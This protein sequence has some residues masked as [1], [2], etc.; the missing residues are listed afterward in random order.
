ML[1]TRWIIT[2]LTLQRLLNGFFPHLIITILMIW[3]KSQGQ[4]QELSNWLTISHLQKLIGWPTLPMKKTIN[5][6]TWISSLKVLKLSISGRRVPYGCGHL[7]ELFP[8]FSL[9]ANST[10]KGGQMRITIDIK[11]HHHSCTQMRTTLQTCKIS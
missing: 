8:C 6:K 3:P 5:L 10:F 2:S 11:E 4:N 9:G 7:W 1:Q